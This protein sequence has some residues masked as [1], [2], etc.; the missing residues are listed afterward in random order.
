[1]LNRRFAAILTLAAWPAIAQA[2]DASPP[3]W[4]IVESANGGRFA[5]CVAQTAG[6][7]GDLR[8][9]RISHRDWTISVPAG[10]QRG[11]VRAF[12]GTEHFTLRADGK[13]AWWVVSNPPYYGAPGDEPET[14]GVSIGGKKTME[15]KLR[16]V[17]AAVKAV[18][19]CTAGSAK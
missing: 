16:G 15:W 13:R 3:G 7:A 5:R 4:R 8:I 17:Q 2:N 6:P 1:M 9:A 11:K 19:Q 18:E 14:I 12:V 10:G